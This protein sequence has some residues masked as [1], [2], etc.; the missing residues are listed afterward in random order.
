MRRACRSTPENVE[1]VTIFYRRTR[2]E[3]PAIPEEIDET[4][5]EGGYPADLDL[6]CSSAPCKDG[7]VTSVEFISNSLGAADS[8]GRCRTSADRRIETCCPD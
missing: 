3:M 6:T 2:A 7:Q 8:S 4:Q 5:E 1:S